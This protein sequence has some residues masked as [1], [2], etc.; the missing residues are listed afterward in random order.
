MFEFNWYP[1][2]ENYFVQYWEPINVYFELDRQ[3]EW[4]IVQN[5]SNG[6]AWFGLKSS[7][8]YWK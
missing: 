7:L 4:D 1:D 2:D 3:I 8:S 6:R 5:T